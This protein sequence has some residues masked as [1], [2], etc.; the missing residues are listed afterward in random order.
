[1]VITKFEKHV[2]AI[3]LNQHLIDFQLD[4]DQVYGRYEGELS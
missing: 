2:L 1:M 4:L 3:L